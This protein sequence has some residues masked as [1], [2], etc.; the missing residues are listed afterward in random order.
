MRKGHP[1]RAVRGMVDEILQQLSPHFDAMYA[2]VGAT[3]DPAEATV[4]SAVAAE[5][6]YSIRSERLLMEEIDY[7][8][9]FRCY[10]IEPGRRSVGRNG[11]H[12]ELRSFAGSRSG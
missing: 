10:W 12:Q 8:M 5:M 6:L 9:L 7:S 2:R 11:V 3:V 1:L 4:A